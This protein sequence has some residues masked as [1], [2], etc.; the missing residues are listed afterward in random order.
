MTSHD[1][2]RRELVD[3]FKLSDTT[4]LFDVFAEAVSTVQAQYIDAICNARSDAE[5]ELWTKRA[6]ALRAYKTAVGP[7]DRGA[8]IDGILLLRAERRQAA[9]VQSVA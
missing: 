4:V 1:Q 2:D 6:G 3:R 7:D 9:G 8:M 5:R